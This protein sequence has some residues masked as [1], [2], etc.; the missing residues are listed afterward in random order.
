M[1][2]I[3]APT[4][5]CKEYCHNDEFG[6]VCAGH[7][8][9][10]MTK[11]LYGR[12]TIGPCVKTD[13]GFVGCSRDVITHLHERCS[14]RQACSVRVPDATLDMT[15]PCNQDLK[16]YLDVSY[17][18]M[19]GDYDLRRRRWVGCYIW[20]SEERAGRAAA[21]PRPLLAVPNVSHPSA[22]SVPTSCY[23]AVHMSRFVAF[24]YKHDY[25]KHRGRISTTTGDNRS[26]VVLGC[27]CV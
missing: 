16:S 25:S 11:A 26:G 18:C 2:I 13:F 21:P 7:S 27:L 4:G 10:L 17:T 5:D 1:W 22:A 9:I 20:Y 12:M 3:V 24:I 15:D 23:Y 14:G 19:P 6:A 8:V